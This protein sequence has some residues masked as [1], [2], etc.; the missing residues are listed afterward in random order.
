MFKKVCL[1]SGG[2]NPAL[3][4]AIANYLETPL[5][6]VKVQRFSDTEPNTVAIGSL[7]GGNS[8]LIPTDSD[9]VQGNVLIRVIARGHPMPPAH[10]GIHCGPVMFKEGDY[11]GQTVIMAARMGDFARPG[12]VLASE[13]IVNATSRSDVAFTE[14]G[15]VELKGVSGSVRLF[16]AHKVTAGTPLP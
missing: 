12:E 16:S 9:P 13:E 4:A 15:P 8:V 5:G 11:F 7:D 14:I 2:A 6:K 1:F 10:V 3:A